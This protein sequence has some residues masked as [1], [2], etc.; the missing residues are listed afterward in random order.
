MLTRFGVFVMQFPLYI[1]AC[2]YVRLSMFLLKISFPLSVGQVV[3][4]VSTKL[5]NAQT[6]MAKLDGSF[7][8]HRK[9]IFK[10]PIS[11]HSLFKF[12]HLMCW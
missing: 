8:S 10:I 2:M 1:Y 11:D 12:V 4:S 9:K 6:L 7:G 3:K 5:Q